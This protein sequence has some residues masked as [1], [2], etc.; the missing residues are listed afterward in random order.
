MPMLNLTGRETAFVQAVARGL[1]NRE[2]AAEFHL[3]E[4]TVK[5]QLTMIYAKLGM[6]SRVQLA[7]FAMRHE[8]I[9]TI[10]AEP[11]NTAVGG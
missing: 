1:S 10:R 4:Q 7:L 8:L 5:N 3:S 2:I 6:R 9:E 11:L